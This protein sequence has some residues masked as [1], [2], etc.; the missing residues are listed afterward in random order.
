MNLPRV[1]TP[2]LQLDVAL[3]AHGCAV[4]GCGRVI[5]AGEELV[6][7][8]IEGT[9]LAEPLCPVHGMEAREDAK[10]RVRLALHAH[11]QKQEHE[12]SVSARIERELLERHADI[13][14]R[15][16]SRFHSDSDAPRSH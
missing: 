8:E 4:E 7:R 5:A 3:E 14:D 13:G 1:R 2:L 16:E 11:A 12:A 9:A 10:L 6:M 15:L